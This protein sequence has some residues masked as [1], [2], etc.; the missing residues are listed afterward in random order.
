VIKNIDI[1]FITYFSKEF[2][3]QGIVAIEA[4]KKYLP[5]KQQLSQTLPK[6]FPNT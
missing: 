6:H 3:V 5:I 1:S 2:L 4:C